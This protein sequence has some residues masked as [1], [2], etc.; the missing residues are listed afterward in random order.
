MLR[1]ELK[2]D[3]NPARGAVKPKRRRG[4]TEK[5]GYWQYIGRRLEIYRKSY[6]ITKRMDPGAYRVIGSELRSTSSD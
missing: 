2:K 5:T 1:G 4:R 6:R 3:K